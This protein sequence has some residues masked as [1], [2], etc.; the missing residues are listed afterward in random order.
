MRPAWQHYLTL[1]A[2]S[3]GLTTLTQTNGILFPLLIQQFVGEQ[4]KGG[5]FGTLR[6]W[7]LMAALLAQSSAGMFSDRC[8][9]RWGRRRPFIVAGTLLGV[10]IIAAIGTL[11]NR[12]GVEAYWLLF[13]LAIMLQ[14]AS[15]IAQGAQQG[16]I[17]DLV[18][19]DQRGRF[20]GFKALFEL[21][22]PLLLVS[23]VIAPM[24]ADWR[25]SQA[26]LVVI[27]VLAGSMLITLLVR[28][29]PL[30]EAQPPVRWAD[31]RRLTLM[32][33]LFT[34]AI[35]GFGSV[36]KAIMKTTVITLEPAQQVVVLGVAAFLGMLG[37]SLVGVWVSV[38]A[39]LGSGSKAHTA[40]TWWVVNRL[41]FLAAAFNLSTF[42]VYFLQARLGLV[43]EE[44]ARPA[45]VLM[46]IIGVLILIFAAPAGWLSD[47]IGHKKMI[48][49]SGIIAGLGTLVVLLYPSLTW[50]YAGGILIGAAM[51]C[52]Y[53][54]NWALGTRLAPRHEAARFLG[55]SN[56]AGAGAGAIGAYIGGPIADFFTQ[57][58]PQA[59]GLGYIVLFAIL[60]MLFL[61]STLTLVAI[62]D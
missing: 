39:G 35:L 40:F 52:F 14:I 37:A 34:A 27:A 11:A 5:Y 2:F 41:T 36:T 19:E 48:A 9:S 10:V 29:V 58:Q 17:P 61:T 18:P 8:A 21:P 51:G 3:L 26:L 59:Q 60:G 56:L 57:S 55:I 12:T 15:N 24:L 50:I 30:A 1:N 46:L 53:A 32:T 38:R 20:S 31:I 45:A 54:A 62:K 28:E 33:A 44:A 43:K 42:A 22:L 25:V 16:L 6:L 23:I 7:S 49:A 47:V 13:M 4:D